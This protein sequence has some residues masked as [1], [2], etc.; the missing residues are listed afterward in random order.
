MKTLQSIV[1]ILTGILCFP[2][3]QPFT[4]PEFGRFE[5]RF[6][7]QGFLIGNNYHE[8]GEWAGLY[9]LNL[10]DGQTTQFSFG[11]QGSFEMPWGVDNRSIH[12]DD[13]FVGF[14][15]YGFRRISLDENY[16]YDNLVVGAYPIN[17]TVFGNRIYFN[18]ST[19]GTYYYDLLTEELIFLGNVDTVSGPLF[20]SMHVAENNMFALRDLPLTQG[21]QGSRLLK[22][23]AD[24]EISDYIESTLDSEGDYI[25]ALFPFAPNGRISINGRE[26]FL[27]QM[28]TGVNKLISIDPSNFH[29]TNFISG[30]L[31]INIQ[32]QMNYIILSDGIIFSINENFYKTN[33]VSSLEQIDFNIEGIFDTGGFHTPSPYNLFS[34]SGDGNSFVQVGDITYLN[35]SE[36]YIE[37]IY[38]MNS[39]DSTPELI[40]ST[41][42]EDNIYQIINY[43]VEWNGNLLF[44]VQSNDSTVGDKIYLYNGSELILNPDLNDFSGRTNNEQPTITGLFTYGELLLVYTEEGVYS[45]EY[46]EMS[47][48]EEMITSKLKIYPNPVKDFIHF[49]EKLKEIKIYDLSGKLIKNHSASTDKLNVNDIPKGNYIITGATES[50][51]KFNQKF[52]KL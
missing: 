43:A 51:N 21:Q 44:V 24:Y 38:K 52:I 14:A 19:Y 3:L 33:G 40:F 10:S 36:N 16:V 39:I 47:V 31:D 50:G 17:G 2:Q 46:D 18:F 35:V 1:L 29:S 27:A 22:V 30:E 20:H 12:Q 8:N 26:I 34:G 25:S 15:N 48:S 5:P 49:S 6:L 7:H 32:S 23:N 37:R 11:Q 4:D 13:I 41:T 9:K 42:H 45:I 28:H